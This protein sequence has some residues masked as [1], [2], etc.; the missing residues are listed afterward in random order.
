MAIGTANATDAFIGFWETVLV[1][2]VLGYIFSW[3]ASVGTRL[4]LSMRLIADRQSP[5]VIWQ[6]GDIGGTTIRSNEHPEPGFESVDQYTEG[7][8]AS[9]SEK[10]D[11]DTDSTFSPD[12]D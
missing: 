3:T 4:F 9:P 8:R 12:Q 6:P 1:A 2:A 10:S 5:S 7:R 11:P